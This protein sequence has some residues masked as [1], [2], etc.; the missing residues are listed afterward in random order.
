MAEQTRDLLI[1]LGTEELPPKALPTLSEV[2]ER[3]VVKG[4]AEAGLSHG[5]VQRY[6]S[7]R[8]LA[9]LIEGL[10]TRQPDRMIERKGPAL[11]AAFR[12]G[13]PTKAALGFARSCGVEL[14]ELDELRTDEGA[15]LL[16]RTEQAGKAAEA[17]VPDIFRQA[18]T[19]L[20][21][22]KRMRWGAGEAAFVRPVHWLV[23]L[24][25]DQVVEAEALGIKAGRITYGHRFHHEGPIELK[26]AADYARQ[27]EDDGLVIAD[28]AA[29]RERIR[30]DTI[31][32]AESIDAEAVI[33]QELLDE[34]TALVEWPV[35]LLGSFD[36]A[37]L[38]VPAEALVSSMQEHQRYFPLRDQAGALLPRFITIANIESRNPEAVREGNERVI[39]PR[40]ADAAFFWDQDRRQR[41]EARRAALAKIVYQTRLGTVLEKSD[42]VAAIAAEAAEALAIDRDLA[43]RAAQLA[44]C[45]L[46]THMVDE[47]PELQGVMGRYY[48]QHDGEPEAVS[49]ALEEQ[50][51]PR[52]GGDRIAGSPVGQVLAIAERVDTLVGI[53][54]IGRQPSG[55]KDPFALRRAALGL[56][57][58]L[59]EGELDL[60]LDWL[61]R[62]G[63]RALPENVN[64][65]GSLSAV[66]DFCM[67]RLRAYYADKGYRPELFE[68]VAATGPA[69]PLDFQRRLQACHAFLALPEAESLAAANKRIRNILRRNEAPLPETVVADLLEDA[70]EQALASAV[71]AASEEVAPFLERGAYQEALQRLAALHAPVDAFFDHVLVMAEDAQIRGNRLRLL[72]DTAEL[73]FGVADVSRLPG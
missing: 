1:E 21:I 59:V 44:K 67:D 33:E 15:W 49:I 4:L 60:D 23:M 66:F 35:A 22:P 53:F 18:L 13:E 42:R 64:A 58:T 63:A 47:F 51:Q 46:S 7:P 45:D 57:R 65:E 72:R 8:R 56:M 38:S 34:V 9:V 20:P 41:L 48:A 25:G 6:A 50:Y 36:A 11:N 39:R 5:Q 24:F 28:F 14:A 3:E 30:A 71:Q 19:R 10:A 27:L 73:F 70:E 32:L 62:I 54:A 52:F 17:L 26:T 2:L 55:D 29:R 37:F 68:A 31:A 12:D 43:V 40:L 69:R 61:L 16:Y